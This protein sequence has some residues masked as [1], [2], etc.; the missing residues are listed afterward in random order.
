[1]DFAGVVHPKPVLVGARRDTIKAESRVNFME[2]DERG[3]VK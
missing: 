2:E 3:V 1:L